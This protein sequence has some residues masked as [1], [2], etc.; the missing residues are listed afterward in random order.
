V[1]T[2]PRNWS[3]KRRSKSSLSAPLS[4]TR[5]L[6]LNVRECAQNRGFIRGMRD[7][8]FAA[9]WASVWVRAFLAY[10]ISRSIAHRADDRQDYCHIVHNDKRLIVYNLWHATIRRANESA[11]RRL[12]VSGLVGLLTCINPISIDELNKWIVLKLTETIFKTGLRTFTRQGSC[13][14]CRPRP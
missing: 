9:T 12:T 4:A 2:E 8:S 5:I 11:Q 1:I 14:E 7:L 13:L 3:I 6:T 10:G